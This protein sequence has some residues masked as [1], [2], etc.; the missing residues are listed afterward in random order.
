MW[1]NAVKT[2]MKLCRPLKTRDG[3]GE[4]LYFVG[5]DNKKAS[6]KAND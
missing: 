3:A 2:A 1:K 6:G 4:I 5:V